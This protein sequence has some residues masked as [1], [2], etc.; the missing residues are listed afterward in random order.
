MP[1]VVKS[2]S[3]STISSLQWSYAYPQ[4]LS[5]MAMELKKNRSGWLV[6]EDKKYQWIGLHK[7]KSKPETIVFT[8]KIMGG[9]CK[10]SKPI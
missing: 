7:G 2:S 4:H 3:S 8:M 9:S 5:W 1:R 6:M 10:L